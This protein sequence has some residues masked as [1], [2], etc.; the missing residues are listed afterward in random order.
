MSPCSSLE[1]KSSLLTSL[2][3]TLHSALT[4][5]PH[6]SH[7]PPLT[8]DTMVTVTQQLC[9]LLSTN[10]SSSSSWLSLIPQVRTLGSPYH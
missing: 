1:E 4:S 3:H 5:L 7:H 2:H 8:T 9:T 6:T 10:D